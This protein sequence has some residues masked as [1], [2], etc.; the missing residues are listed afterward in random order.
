MLIVFRRRGNKSRIYDDRGVRL[1]DNRDVCDCLNVDCPGCHM[2]C[3]R[4][5]SAKCGAECRVNRIW[6]YSEVEI[7]GGPRSKIVADQLSQPAELSQ[8]TRR[9][10]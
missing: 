3:P 6:F 9:I 1:C 7:E 4:C 8:L 5:S 10:S 2:P